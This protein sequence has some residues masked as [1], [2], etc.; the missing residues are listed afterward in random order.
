MRVGILRNAIKELNAKV[1]VLLSI[2]LFLV[3]NAH[4]LLEL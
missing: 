2:C 4:L 3:Q 1:V